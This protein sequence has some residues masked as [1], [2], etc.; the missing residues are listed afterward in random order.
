MDS[1]AI[2]CDI[3]EYMYMYIG[4]QMKTT[5]RRKGLSISPVVFFQVWLGQDFRK[6]KQGK[7]Q[8][9]RYIDYQY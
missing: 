2:F 8:S 1:N 6:Q 3:L 9:I 4:S 5:S 7:K